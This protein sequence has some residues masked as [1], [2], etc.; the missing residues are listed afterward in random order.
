M[1]I[2][3]TLHP[4]VIMVVKSITHFKLRYSPQFKVQ[5]HAFGSV[6]SMAVLALVNNNLNIF[7]ISC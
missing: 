3:H 2:P 6:F 7:E 4:C 1:L 5:L